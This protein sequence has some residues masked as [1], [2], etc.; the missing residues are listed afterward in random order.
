[1]DLV[2]ELQ[3]VLDRNIKESRCLDLESLCIMAE[4]S[5]W[6][7]RVDITVSVLV[8]LR[9]TSLFQ[10]SLVTLGYAYFCSFN[11]QLFLAIWLVLSLGN[12]NRQTWL[13]A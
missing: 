11:M 9:Q 1:M 13:L 12:Q 7:F 2:D 4:E 3:Q 8:L 5:V 6:Q 10:I